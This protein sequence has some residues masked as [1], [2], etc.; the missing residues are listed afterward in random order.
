[1]WRQTSIFH[2]QSKGNKLTPIMIHNRRHLHPHPSDVDLEVTPKFFLGMSGQ[3]RSGGGQGIQK[4]GYAGYS[5]KFSY[6][7]LFLNGAKV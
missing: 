4:S 5:I 7:L 6:I 2:T 1:M 3:S